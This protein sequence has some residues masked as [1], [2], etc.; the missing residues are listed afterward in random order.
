MEVAASRK[1]MNKQVISM[2]GLYPFSFLGNTVLSFHF[3]SLP[4]HLAIS[5]LSFRSQVR[6]A[7]PNMNNIVFLCVSLATAL[8]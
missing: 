3:S 2:V 8:P 1:Q 7:S 4:V 5:G 6:L